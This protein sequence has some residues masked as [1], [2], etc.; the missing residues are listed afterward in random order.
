MRDRCGALNSRVFDKH[1]TLPM[2]S[3]LSL[4]ADA[5]DCV[6]L[7]CCHVVCNRLPASC[8]FLDPGFLSP[9][10][11]MNRPLESH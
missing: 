11:P 7:L 10:T 8:I 5:S 3:S 9:T 2:H 1:T 4:A 6:F